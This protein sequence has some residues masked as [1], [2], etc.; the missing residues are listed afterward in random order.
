MKEY[1][2]I[3]VKNLDG[4]TSRWYIGEPPKVMNKISTP[5]LIKKPL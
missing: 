4:K 2:E 1:K 5:K 3:I